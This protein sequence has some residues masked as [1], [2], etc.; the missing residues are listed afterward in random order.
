[1]SSGKKVVS[2]ARCRNFTPD[3]PRQRVDVVYLCSPNNPTGTVASR[4]TLARWVAYARAN[5]SRN[6]A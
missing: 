3:V 4:E 5:D 2:S 1:M 6:A